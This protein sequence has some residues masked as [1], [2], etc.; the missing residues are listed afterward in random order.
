[1]LINNWLLLVNISPIIITLIFSLIKKGIKVHRIIEVILFSFLFLII[2]YVTK[3][4]D[5]DYQSNQTIILLLLSLSHYSII[6][7]IIHFMR[8]YSVF[9]RLIGLLLEVS[10][11]SVYVNIETQ[12]LVLF[13]NLHTINLFMLINVSLL[14]LPVLLYLY[15][16]RK[17]N[18]TPFKQLV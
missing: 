5:V 9:Q 13:S 14:L 2:I 16:S 4:R 18:I 3:R 12:K 8:N 11:F 1:M 10:L 17:K 6:N 7:L 15:S